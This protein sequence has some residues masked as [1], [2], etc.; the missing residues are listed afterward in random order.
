M[1]P[2]DSLRSLRVK[3]SGFTLL[4][5]LVAVAVFAMISAMVWY[6]I[7]QTFRTIEIVQA[8][9]DMLRQARQVTSRVPAELSAAFLPFNA[10][11]TANVKFEFVGEDEGDT[12]RV[13]FASLAHTKLYADANESDQS[14]IEYFCEADSKKGG[15]YRLFRREDT[16]IDDRADE[17]GVTLLMAEDV[18]EFQLSYYDPQ[19]DEWIEE[20]DTTRTDQSNRLPYAVR[21]KLTLIDPDGFERTW[22]TASTIRLAKP[23]EQR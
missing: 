2:F 13:R 11:P 1:A 7:A 22:F 3:K 21:L 6:S 10:S 17:G 12:D 18:K 4:E 19:R 14:E 5:V 8:P 16:V 23:Q 9:G 20:W 15:T